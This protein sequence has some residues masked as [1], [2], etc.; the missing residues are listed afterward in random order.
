VKWIFF[1]KGY[2]RQRE[3]NSW[4]GGNILRGEGTTAKANLRKIWPMR[5]IWNGR[6]V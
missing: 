1:K 6:K 5:G 3:L 2:I 4:K